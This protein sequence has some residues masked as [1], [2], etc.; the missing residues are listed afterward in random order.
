MPLP[1]VTLVLGGAASGKSAFAEKL[2]E[3]TGRP[4]VYIATAQAQDSEMAARIAHHRASRGRHWRTVEAPCDLRPALDSASGDEVLLID[5]LTLWLSNHLL[6]EN[7][8]DKAPDALFDALAVCAAPV[9]AVSN[10]VGLSVVPDNPLA[11]RFRQAQG[12]LNQHVAAR[13]GLVI[14]V[15]AGLPQVLKGQLP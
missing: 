10:E 11:R 3:G 9:I 8:P 1:D 15:I 7:D 5:C 13:A 12:E 2:A 6:A 14:N 4:C